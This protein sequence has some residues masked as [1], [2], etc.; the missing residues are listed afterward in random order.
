MLWK[1]FMSMC[2]ITDFG[3][4][5][6]PLHQCEVKGLFNMWGTPLQKPHHGRTQT[7]FICHLGVILSFPRPL[8]ELTRQNTAGALCIQKNKVRLK[9]SQ[10]AVVSSYHVLSEGWIPFVVFEWLDR[11][12]IFSY[13][14]FVLVLNYGV[15]FC[16]HWKTN[17]TNKQKPWIYLDALYYI[18]SFHLCVC[19]THSALYF[20][21][22]R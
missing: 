8:P 12:F 6:L 2:M 13:W 5:T 20:H 7:W 14:I 10:M 3:L 9:G 1:M 17:K 19:P 11:I 16:L 22:R 21:F 15:R 18:S 4:D